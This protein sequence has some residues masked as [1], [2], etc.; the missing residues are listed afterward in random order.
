MSNIGKEGQPRHFNEVDVEPLALTDRKKRHIKISE[1][2]QG[3]LR[4]DT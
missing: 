2:T 3:C 1:T 4:V